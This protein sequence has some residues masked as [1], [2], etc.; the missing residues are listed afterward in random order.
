MT[1]TR[2]GLGAVGLAM[3]VY[4]AWL[5][6][7]RG[8]DLLDLVIWL[9][10]GVVLHDAVLSMAVLATG[11]LAMRALPRVARAPAAVGF[12]VLGSVTLCPLGSPW[13]EIAADDEGEF[14]M[15]AVDPVAQGRGVGDALVRLAVERSAR[16]GCRGM[17]LSSL[18]SMH[19]AHRLYARH[20]FRPAPER[21]WSPVPGTDLCAYVRA[22]TPEERPG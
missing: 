21:D 2:L 10:A 18:P 12:V 16:D 7:S 4:G 5:V 22:L 14:R 17:V 1:A 20:G 6:L 9:G 8:H 13:R 3:G 19:A 11:A 15:L